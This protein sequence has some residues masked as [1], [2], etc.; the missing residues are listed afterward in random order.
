MDGQIRDCA[1]RNGLEYVRDD[2]SMQ[3]SFDALPVIMNFFYHE[4]IKHPRREAAPP[5]HELLEVGTVKRF[6][7]P[8]LVENA[9][10][11]V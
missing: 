6:L 3:K 8:Q 11:I 4:E 2:D 1:E 9:C 5:M 7:A 10:T